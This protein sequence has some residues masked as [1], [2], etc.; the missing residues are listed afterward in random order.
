MFGAGGIEDVSSAE[1]GT[2]TAESGLD[3]D[4]F[5]GGEELGCEL[6]EA[7]DKL[8]CGQASSL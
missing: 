7:E 5:L 3:L 1:L 6:G 4:G 2:D 8:E